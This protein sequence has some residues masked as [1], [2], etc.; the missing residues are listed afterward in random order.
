MDVERAPSQAE[1][2]GRAVFGK[3]EGMPE[4]PRSTSR[5]IAWLLLAASF[6]VPLLISAG[7][8]AAGVPEVVATGMCPA[9]PPDVPAYSCTVLDYV[10]RMTVGPWALMGHFAVWSVWCGFVVLVGSG[11]LLVRSIGDLRRKRSV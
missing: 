3:H 9:A 2:F 6:L 8:V 4:T 10:M 7:T 11:L 1:R 5:R